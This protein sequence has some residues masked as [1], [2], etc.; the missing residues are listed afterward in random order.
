MSRTF[1]VPNGM[2]PPE[3]WG[4]NWSSKLGLPI[5]DDGFFGRECPN[6]DCLEFFK[7][8]VDDYGA[9]RAAHLLTCPVCGTTES[10]EHFH[11]TDQVERMRAGAM[12]LARGAMNQILSEFSRRAP[13]RNN[14]GGVTLRWNAPPPYTPKPLPTYLERQTIRTFT[15]P[16][17]G[18]RAV[19]YDLLAFC[20]FCGP[21]RTPPLAVFSDNL[22]AMRRLLAVVTELPPEAQEAIRAAGGATALAERAV[23][24]AVAAVQTL[25]KQLHAQAEKPTPKGNPWQNVDRLRRQWLD[26]FGVDPL[27][28][29]D[30]T[31][32]NVLRLGFARRHVLEHNGGVVDERYRQETGTGVIGQRIR[33]RTAFVEQVFEA[34]AVLAGRLEAI[35][36]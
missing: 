27:T 17:G 34:A 23:G 18:H 35:A 32:V 19:I 26:A 31:D 12:E 16:H 9:A 30:P 7:L 4:S 10:D 6:P 33:I 15:C 13:A 20:P 1:R 14:S 2:T 11:T 28:G 24:S 3:R 36:R 5:D 25:A 8:H 21:E 22:A 29:L